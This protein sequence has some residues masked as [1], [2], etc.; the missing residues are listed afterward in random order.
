MI[1]KHFIIKMDWSEW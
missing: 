1:E